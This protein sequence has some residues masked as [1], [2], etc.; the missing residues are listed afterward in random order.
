MRT[1]GLLSALLVFT[2]CSA[3][4]FPESSPRWARPSTFGTPVWDGAMLRPTS[5]VATVSGSK[6]YVA[7][8]QR[9][10]RA[11]DLVAAPNDELTVLEINPATNEVRTL[12][13]PPLDGATPLTLW[14]S[15]S[16]GV[17]AV[18]GQRLQA[19]NG[20]TWA[21]LPDLPTQR[22][23]LVRRLTADWVLVRA[24]QNAWVLGA[25]VWRPLAP[26]TP[27]TTS[28]VFGPSSQSET[29]L[30]WTH[31]SDGLCTMRVQLANLAPID[32][33]S[34]RQG[35]TD[36]LAGDAIN[37][38]SDDF[39]AWYRNLS[40]V[41]LLHF[42]SASGWAAPVITKGQTLRAT[43]TSVDAVVS[44]PLS[45]TVPIHTLLRASSGRLTE[46]LY[47]HSW[48]LL[49]CDGVQPRTC[50]QRLGALTQLVSEDGA[51]TYFLL[52]NL[53]DARRSLYLKAVTLPHRDTG[54]CSPACTSSQLC[55]RGSSI[56]NL[57]VADPAH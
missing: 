48:E 9:A 44:E 46:A 5:Y 25:G 6:I 28:R 51:T 17:L 33:P 54:E 4:V 22:P 55:V 27:G 39:H 20:S 38:T 57:C 42:T 45:G 15:A 23:D 43:P 30:V 47:V 3:W 16:G 10:G 53:V 26:P 21:S 56:A 50:A 29:R 49:G 14:A 37:G 32:S 7:V 31:G 41:T 24:G 18:Q 11:V 52:E 34:C 12:P 1:F 8:S 40:D 2:G 35:P 13:T 19:F 36:V